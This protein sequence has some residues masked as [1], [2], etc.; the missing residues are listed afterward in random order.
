MRKK[1]VI[2]GAVIALLAGIGIGWKYFS[3]GN[4]K[5]KGFKTA[6]IERGDISATVSATGTLNALVTVL[7]G[8]Q[9]SGTIKELHAD[10]NSV[11]KKGQVIARL[12]PALFIEQVNQAKANLLNASA[13][14]EKAK[15]GVNDAKRNFERAKDLHL[16]GI[17]SQSDF[18][19]TQ[20]NYESALAQ[21]NAASAQVEQS[22]AARRLSEVNLS[23][24]II[25]A[26]V[27]GVVISRNVDVG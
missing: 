11:V 16:K 6:K 10:F 4:R 14:L 12:D 18:D 3:D 15:V 5:T 7:V 26:P 2:I 13:N 19:V 21:M 1:F 27:D 25:K 23:N 9:V 17:I 24:T 20:A 8:S 22:K